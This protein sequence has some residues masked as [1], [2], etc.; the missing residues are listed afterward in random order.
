MISDYLLDALNKLN[1]AII[2]YEFGDPNGRNGDATIPLDIQAAMVIYEA[3]KAYHHE[4]VVRESTNAAIT[5]AQCK[6]TI[7]RLPRAD[8]CICKVPELPVGFT[9]IPA[10]SDK[11][12]FCQKCNKVLT[13]TSQ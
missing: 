13:R 1:I 7:A 2:N 10:N 4:G 12:L 8:R 6:G 5:T 11:K 3:A 9:Q